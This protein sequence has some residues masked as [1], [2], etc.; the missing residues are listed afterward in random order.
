M[1][2]LWKNNLIFV[3]DVPMIYVNFITFVVIVSDGK[4]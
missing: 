3:K 4:E 2:N 1:E